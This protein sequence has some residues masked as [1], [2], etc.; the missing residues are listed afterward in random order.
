MCAGKHASGNFTAIVDYN[1]HQSYSSTFEVQDL[2]PFAD[3]WRSFGF[4][5]R[6]VDGHDVDCAA[7]DAARH[8]PSR[9]AG[10]SAVICHTIKGKGVAF[11]ENNMQLAS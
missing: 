1:K 10:P 4:A 6:E 5:V 8:C 7:D 9:Q 3:K 2:E 11:A